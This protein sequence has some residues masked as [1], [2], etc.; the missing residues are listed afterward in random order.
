MTQRN[1]DGALA[2]YAGHTTTQAIGWNPN[3]MCMEVCRTARRIGPMYPSALSAQH[4]TPGSKR[5]TKL[6]NIRRGMVMFFDDP[7]D[8]N[9]FGHIVTVSGRAAPVVKSLRDLIVWTN[10]VKSGQLV[11]VRAD[12]FPT[13]WE[14]QFQ[15][16]AT[17]LNGQDLLIPAKPGL[18]A[19]GRGP[20]LRHAIDDI[21]QMIAA[22]K[23]HP[24]LVNA[25]Q[26]DLAELQETLRRFS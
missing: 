5:I 25:L 16:A 10:S 11:R 14:D 17:W 23:D 19:E 8:N 12:F 13:H 26:R 3:G 4:A 9:P 6:N 21:K 20:R 15:F 24:R 1:T 22:N 7:N 2:W 18:L